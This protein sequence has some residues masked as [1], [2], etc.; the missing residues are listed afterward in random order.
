[1]KIFI[2]YRRD[3]TRHLAG[4]LA[5]R[6]LAA[7]NVEEVFRDVV[8]IAPGE[9]FET[10]MLAAVDTCDLCLVLIG[11]AWASDPRLA[12][13]TDAVRREV[14]TALVGAAA[15]RIRL[16]PILV[17]RAQMPPRDALPD[18][19][20]ALSSINA[21][22]LAYE[23]F[24]R[25]VVSLAETLGIA[26]DPARP[27]YITALRALAGSALGGLAL[28]LVALVHWAIIGRSL[29]TT[30]GLA[31]L[32]LLLVVLPATGAGVALARGRRRRA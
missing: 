11:E 16:V 30:V 23:T 24:E 14:A 9:N 18:D 5:D 22:R 21:P 28:F 1:M 4:R 12:D 27:W 29:E 8:S 19:L 26:V 7:A 15:G 17:G 31:G 2:S 25:D 20:A 3:D 13:P 32:I 10:A 6:F